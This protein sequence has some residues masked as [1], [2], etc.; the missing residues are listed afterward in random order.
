MPIA[1]NQVVS[2][3]YRLTEGGQ[4]VESSFER[5]QPLHVL[6]GHGNF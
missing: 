4:P 1:E 5:N 3:H 2:L 6:I